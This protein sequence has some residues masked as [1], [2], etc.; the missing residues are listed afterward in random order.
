MKHNKTKITKPLRIKRKNNFYLIQ[1]I[2]KN[3]LM[4]I[5]IKTQKIQYIYTFG[6]LKWDK[7]P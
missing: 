5:S 4:Y 3:R 7:I 1:Q 6:H 2:P